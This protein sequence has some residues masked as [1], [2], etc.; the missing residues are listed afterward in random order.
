MRTRLRTT[1]I[2]LAGVLTL[3]GAAA[4]SEEGASDTDGVEQEEGEGN[5]EGD[6][7]GEQDVEEDVEEEG[8]IGY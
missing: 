3:T 2:A 7:E 8:G 4:C 1:T 6:P 5:L